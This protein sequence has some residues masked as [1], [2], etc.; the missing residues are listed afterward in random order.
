MAGHSKWAQIKRSKGINDQKR[1][2]LFT[3]IGNQIAVAARGGSDPN[4]NFALRMVIDTAKAANMPLANIERAIQRAADKSLA[5]VEEVMYEGYGPNGVAILVECATDNRNRTFPEVRNAFNKH[6]GAIAD[7]GSVAFQFTKKGYIRISGSG[8]DLMLSV[9]DA[10]A[11]DVH[12]EG[13]EMI[14]YTDPKAV[15]AVRGALAKL[16][17][18]IL[19][20][21]LTYVANTTVS[22]TDEVTEGKVMRLLEAIEDL[23]DVLNT[24]T[25]L[26]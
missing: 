7:P 16:N 15:A 18:P 20:A 12:E 11:E 13:E 24:H 19:E 9:L 3:K 26:A 4:S 22:I 5:Q 2:A 8:D 21:G 25:N 14:V 17:I 10:G 6:G 1:G 23:D